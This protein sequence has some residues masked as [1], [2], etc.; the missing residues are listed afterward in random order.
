MFMAY[1]TRSGK[2]FHQLLKTA[3]NMIFLMLFKIA[4]IAERSFS[5]LEN[6]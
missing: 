6:D 2:P 3:I 1:V 4:P 5:A